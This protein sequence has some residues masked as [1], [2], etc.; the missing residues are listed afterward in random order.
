MKLEKFKFAVGEMFGSFSAF[1]RKNLEEDPE[2]DIDEPVLF[3]CFELEGT[4]EVAYHPMPRFFQDVYQQVA[5]V[6]KLAN[7]T[8]IPEECL[9]FT[10]KTTGSCRCIYGSCHRRKFLKLSGC[11]Q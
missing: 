3:L 7:A 5:V 1:I 8:D 4:D 10:D 6:R 2:F 9:S 11:R